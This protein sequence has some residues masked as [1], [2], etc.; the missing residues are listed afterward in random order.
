MHF[1]VGR[2]GSVDVG[3]VEDGFGR[4]VVRVACEFPVSPCEEC[5]KFV[6]VAGVQVGI[7]VDVVRDLI[8]V[9]VGDEGV[10]FSGECVGA[11]VGAFVGFGGRGF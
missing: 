5:L 10:E 11:V 2:F 3:D 6:V 9:G 1:A 8:D 4:V 7:V